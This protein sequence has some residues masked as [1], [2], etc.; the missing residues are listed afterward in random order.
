MDAIPAAWPSQTSYH[1]S[2]ACT[3]HVVL[4]LGASE[5]KGFILH[6]PP[7]LGP[8]TFS[9]SHLQARLT[10]PHFIHTQSDPILTLDLTPTPRSLPMKLLVVDPTV[11]AGVKEV[12]PVLTETPGRSPGLGLGLGLGMGSGLEWW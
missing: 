4:D 3:V 8:S 11:E 5:H 12:L 10:H 2:V 9:P 6:P 1:P 7:S